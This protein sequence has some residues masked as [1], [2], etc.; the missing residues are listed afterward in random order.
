MSSGLSVTTHKGFDWI[1]A[2]PTNAFLLATLIGIF[3]YFYGFLRLYAGLPISLWSWY[4][5]L[6]Q[7]NQEHS[8]LVPLVFLFLLYYHREALA[9]AKKKGSNWGLL[10]L[11]V[12]ILLY[13][14]AARALQARLALGALPFLFSGI[15]LFVWGKEVARILLFPSAFL[16]FLIPL[17]AIEQTSFR[18]QF[19]ITGIA[20]WL[21]GIFGIKVYAVGTTLRA[22]DGS[23]GFD[24]AEGCS[25]IRSLIAMTMITAIYV[26]IVEKQLW[27]KVTIFALSLVFAII[28][29]A[30]RIFTIIIIAKLGFPE[31]AGGLYHEYSGFVFF[32]IA[33]AVMVLTSKLLNLH[34][35]EVKAKV[36][37]LGAKEKQT[38]DY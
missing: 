15:L 2:N 8:K 17:A 38:Y 6:P 7:Y 30:G 25:G 14:I 20:Q 1:K 31:F 23:W 16:I 34:P 9:K 28:G 18:L 4:R 3:V 21:S 37:A 10:V 5:W 11:G 32:P 35:K 24:I 33:L 29:N 22:V 12:G 27:K 13:V 36:G 26:H 19:L